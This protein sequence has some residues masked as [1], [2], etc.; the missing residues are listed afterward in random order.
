MRRQSGDKDFNSEMSIKATGKK[1]VGKTATQ[2][3]IWPFYEFCG[4]ISD[5]FGRIY[6]HARFARELSERDARLRDLTQQICPDRTVQSGPF[7]GLKYTS[8]SY[9]SSLLPK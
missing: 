1:W 2:P 5:A 8:Q 9:G 4:R 3:M 7:H 6:G